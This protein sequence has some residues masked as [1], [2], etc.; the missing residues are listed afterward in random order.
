MMLAKAG[1]LGESVGDNRSLVFA[2]GAGAVERLL[3]RRVRNFGS[4]V[5][6]F[7]F[8]LAFFLFRTG[9]PHVWRHLGA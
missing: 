2:V 8:Y 4:D 5:A 9:V 7:A 6:D 3:N 1:D